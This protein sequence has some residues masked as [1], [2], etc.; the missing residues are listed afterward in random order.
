VRALKDPMALTA[1]LVARCARIEPDPGPEPG[2]RTFSDE[3]YD[4]A[5][6]ALL[7]QK[8]PGPLWIFAY[9]SLI[10]KP[11]FVAVEHWRASAFGWHRA[12]CLELTRWRGSPQQPGLMMGLERGGRCDG[13]LYRLPDGDHAE[14]LGRLLRREIG[15][16]EE[17]R[18]VRW[19]TVKTQTG[20]RRALTFWAG[21]AGLDYSVKLPLTRVAQILARACGHIGSG[22]DYLFQTVSKL[23]EF[24]IR[25]RNLWRLQQLVAA[26]ILQK[27]AADRGAVM[28]ESTSPARGAAGP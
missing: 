26:E 10:W 6:A 20:K 17:M 5:A 1:E 21:P 25:D 24:G 18:T 15:G 12:F 13:V 27:A 19:I 23:E 11:A 4:A 8:P 7:Q 22:A 28:P 9:G 14:Q 3:E 16:H 2:Y